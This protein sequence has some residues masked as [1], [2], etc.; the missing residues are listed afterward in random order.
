MG[1]NGRVDLIAAKLERHCLRE[2]RLSMVMLFTAVSKPRDIL[3]ADVM[4]ADSV[5]IGRKTP[6]QR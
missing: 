2:T 3:K 4:K 1:L 6:T 5:T